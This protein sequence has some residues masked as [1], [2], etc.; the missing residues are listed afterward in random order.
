MRN[1]KIL[2]EIKE[3]NL[4]YIRFIESLK[5]V[6]LFIVSHFKRN[7]YFLWTPIE[8]IEIIFFILYQNFFPTLEFLLKLECMRRIIDKFSATFYWPLNLHLNRDNKKIGNKLTN[9]WQS[10]SEWKEQVFLSN[11]FLECF[12]QS[13]WPKLFFVL[14]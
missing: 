6:F 11:R 5:T 10:T 13:W 2:D 14:I 9:T 4:A 3:K 7:N 8:K 1:N 12:K